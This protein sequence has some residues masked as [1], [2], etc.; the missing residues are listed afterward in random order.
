MLVGMLLLASGIILGP[1]IFPY[2]TAIPMAFSGGVYASTYVV[3]AYRNSLHS[4]L[5][6]RR[7]AL[8]I[9]MSFLGWL[10][11]WPTVIEGFAVLYALVRPVEYFHIVA[12]DPAAAG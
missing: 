10:L 12:K 3:G 8:N 7:R 11:L 9:A 5:S 4:P 1:A 6:G 2:W